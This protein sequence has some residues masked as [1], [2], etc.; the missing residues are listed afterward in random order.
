[1][2]ATDQSF[3]SR[4]QYDKVPVNPD[5]SIDLYFGRTKPA[6]VDDKSWVQTLKDRVFLVI[7]R[8][9]GAETAFYDQTWKPDDVVKLK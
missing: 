3:P 6:G 8:L 4:N 2:P 1:M 5:G 7:I 9:Y